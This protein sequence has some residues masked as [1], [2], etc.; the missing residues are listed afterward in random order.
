MYEIEFAYQREN[1]TN[2]PIV[3]T[4]SVT[5]PDGK[6]TLFGQAVCH[7][8]DNPVKEVGRKLALARAIA[9]L[10]QAERK[11]VWKVYFER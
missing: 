5:L 7:E 1:Y 6:S 10:P 3:T 2:K 11:K 8:F 9:S 4:A